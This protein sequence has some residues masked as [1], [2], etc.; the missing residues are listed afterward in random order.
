MPS[1]N[2]SDA[3]RWYELLFDEGEGT[4]PTEWRLI[5]PHTGKVASHFGRLEEVQDHL[6][7]ANATGY[8]VY[9]VINRAGH[10]LGPEALRDEL[11]V[12][13]RAV[14]VEID[15]AETAP[16]EHFERLQAAPL[17]PSLVVQSSQA[18][19]L[20]AYWRLEDGMAPDEFRRVQRALARH[21]GGDSSVCNPSRVMRVAGF[22]HTKAENP[23]DW[24]MSR[25]LEA[26]G[27]RYT[28]AEVFEAFGNI[29][30]ANTTQPQ[31][32]GERGKKR[33]GEALL[34]EVREALERVRGDPGESG[35]HEAL[36]KLAKLYRVQGMDKDTA[37][38][39]LER[40][41]ATMPPRPS[42]E[43]P[44]PDEVGGVLDWAWE[45]IEP[46]G[47]KS[48]KSQ[49]EQAL[50]ALE[51]VELWRDGD[52]NAYLTAMVKGHAEH[53]RLPSKAAKDHVSATHYRQAGEGLS[54]QALQDTLNTLSARAAVEGRV[55]PVAVRVMHCEGHTYL[56]LGNEGW[57]VVKVGPGGWSLMASSACPVR[58]IRP[59]GLQPLPTPVKGSSLEALESYL[60]TDRRGFLLMVAWLVAGLSGLGP[61]P[62]LV[63]GGE[64]GSGKSTASKLL[65]SLLDPNTAMLRRP[66]KEERDLFIAARNSYCV[67]Y[68]NLSG[69][70]PWLSDAL[71]VLSTGGAFA[72]RELYSNDEETLLEV[73]RPAILNGIPD[74]LTR[75]DLAD[76]ALMVTLERI[77]DGEREKEAVF[78]A[79]FSRESGAILGAALTALAVGLE[80]LPDTEL[81]ESPRMA[82]FAALI[83][84]AEP[85]LPWQPGEFLS[86]YADARKEAGASV[87]EGDCVA[88]ALLGWLLKADLPW[89]GTAK[90]LLSAL[91]AQ[92]G[93]TDSNRR[94]PEGWPKTPKGLSSRLRQLA[95]ALAQ[96]G[97][98]VA[99][100]SKG[101][102][103][104]RLRRIE[105]L[106][107][108]QGK[109]PPLPPLQLLEAPEGVEPN[110]NQ[111]GGGVLPPQ[112]HYLQLVSDL[113][114][115][116]RLSKGDSAERGSP[117]AAPTPPLE[118]RS[119]GPKDGKGGRGATPRPS[120]ANPGIVTRWADEAE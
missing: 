34:T 7:R 5:H 60:N 82:D 71:C 31:T 2:S 49:K 42:G 72:T 36:L 109:K 93:L 19:K 90:T 17:T 33:L 35:R 104:E 3:Q 92:T 66:P 54:A 14:W 102:N 9:A 68:E 24:I 20:H 8:G 67:A 79:R 101:T 27:A 108:G 13:A 21:F 55:Y 80:R 89:E 96:V 29:L 98:K 119:E 53:Y 52:G 88:E 1:F 103:G 75:P 73:K 32:P 47:K 84:A 39:T 113:P 106:S 94:K 12:S 91:E 25:I 111:N 4:T 74:L 95:P 62:L 105:R 10:E 107:D 41:A 26:D 70:P 37:R 87:L 97:Y 120:S 16:G 38:F 64:A 100:A 78:W 86:L 110:G 40:E 15:Q 115:R 6:Q 48:R 69:I 59:K 58:F 45:N 30:A 56:D 57:E 85:A 61:F 28:R 117:I 50:E 22:L 112:R 18:H 77:P 23:R 81:S 83:V 65:R 44:P 63:L 116:E 46:E 51:D 99:E 76:R 118:A 11:I 43:T 114:P